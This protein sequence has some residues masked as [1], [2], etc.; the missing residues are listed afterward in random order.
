MPTLLAMPSHGFTSLMLARRN[1]A[2]AD[3]SKPQGEIA[4][5][6][7]SQKHAGKG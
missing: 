3:A 7:G 4:Q 6:Q 5:P 1:A 2:S